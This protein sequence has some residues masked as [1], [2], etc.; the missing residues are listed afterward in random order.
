MSDRSVRPRVLYVLDLH[1]FTRC[2]GQAKPRRISEHNHSFSMDSRM[3]IFMPPMR[4]TGNLKMYVAG[5]LPRGSAT[6]RCSAAERSFS[7]A[8]TM[9]IRK[10]SLLIASP[11]VFGIVVPRK[12]LA[13]C[14]SL[15]G[16]ACKG[17]IPPEVWPS[18]RIPALPRRLGRSQPAGRRCRGT[19]AVATSDP[20]TDVLAVGEQ[21]LEVGANLIA[22]MGGVA[23]G[24]GQGQ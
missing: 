3:S 8:P 4:P 24:E 11:K 20:L 13:T 1:R 9:E 12:T 15:S 10:L 17:A 2:Y 19:R 14:T 21:V 23:W 16:S 7:W 5:E 18:G 6:A 22:A